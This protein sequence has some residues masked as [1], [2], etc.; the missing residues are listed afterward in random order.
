MA[1]PLSQSRGGFSI[2]TIRFPLAALGFFGLLA[3]LGAWLVQ[4]SFELLPRILIAAGVLLLGIYVALDPEDVWT[5]ITGRGALYS[6]NTVAIALAAVVILA[7]FNV[8]GSRYQSKWDL[9]ANQQFTLSDQSIKIAQALP[10]PVHI[11]GWLTTDDSRKQ[12]FQTLLNDYSNRSGG[13]VSYEFIDP[14]QRPAE[15]GAA[16]ITAT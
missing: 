1:S 14:V 6:G 12:D 7:L 3:G 15:A 13:K 4:G 9:T 5:K 11:T 16:G 8:L 10:Q 2:E